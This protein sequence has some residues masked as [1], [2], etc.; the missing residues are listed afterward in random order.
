MNNEEP[1]LVGRYFVSGI[2]P[3]LLYGCDRTLILVVSGLCALLV[4]MW[5]TAWALLLAVGLWF[6]ARRYLAKMAKADPLMA[7]VYLRRLLFRRF[8]AA[9]RTLWSSAR[10]TPGKWIHR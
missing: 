6:L 10:W 8:Y 5:M 9:R 7:R 1:D 2:R 3:R 4:Y